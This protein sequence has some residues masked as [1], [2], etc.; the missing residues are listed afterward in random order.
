M[1]ST[2]NVEL[3][4]E[5]SAELPSEST[6]V[7]LPIKIPS[8]PFPV[9]PEMVIVL[10]VEPVPETAIVPFAVPVLFNVTCEEFNVTELAPS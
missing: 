3:A 2:V 5:A 9:I 4:P 1:L 7:L 6:A 10:V 8:V